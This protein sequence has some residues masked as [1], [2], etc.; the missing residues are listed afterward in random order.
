MGA[1]V[2]EKVKQ[3]EAMAL[4]RLLEDAGVKEGERNF[5]SF[6]RDKGIIGGKAVLSQHLTC[7][8]SISL[9]QAIAY[10][11]AFNRP[12]RDFSKRIADQIEEAYWAGRQ[13]QDDSTPLTNIEKEIIAGYKA[14]GEEGQRMIRTLTRDALFGERSGNS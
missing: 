11:R 13:R 4:R 3:S 2:P 5:A 7:I 14:A 10:A 1:P 12:I 6:A 8:R 9:D